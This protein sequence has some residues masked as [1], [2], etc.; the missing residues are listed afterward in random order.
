[1]TPDIPDPADTRFRLQQSTLRLTARDPVRV[2]YWLA[3]HQ[4]TEQLSVTELAA[5][6]GIHESGLPPLALCRTPGPDTFADDV[7]VIAQRCGVHAATLANLLRQE[8]TLISWS[9]PAATEQ[10]TQSA[11]WLLAAHDA[12]QPPPGGDDDDPGRD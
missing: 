9:E 7:A 3:R 8:Q 12:D 2:G 10:P 6:L 1:M 4:E 11:N 5:K